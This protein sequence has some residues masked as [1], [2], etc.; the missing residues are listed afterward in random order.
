MTS[1]GEAPEDDTA[2]ELLDRLEAELPLALPSALQLGGVDPTPGNDLYEAFLF[3]LVLRAARG[4]GYEVTFHQR[5]GHPPAAFRLRRS[6][7]RLASGDFTH[8]VLSLP[9][10]SKSPLEVHTGVAVIG[11]SKVAHE[12]DVLVIPGDIASR[13]RML[14]IDPRSHQ[15]VLVVEGK[16]YSSPLSLGMG[17]QFLGLNVDLSADYTIMAATVVSQSVSH[18]LQGR[19]QYYEFGVL[20][21]RKG[22]HD[23]T[24]RF[25]IALRG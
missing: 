19:K 13:C 16:Y 11:K 10:V 18:L 12:A 22:E 9:G 14:G 21:G 8:A 5:S 4:E 6:P 25:A 17:R 24:E 23:L 2:Q 20:P 7:G 3:A 1:Q 15:A